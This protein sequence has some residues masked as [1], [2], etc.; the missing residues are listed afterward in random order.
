MPSK[1][2]RLKNDL[3]WAKA[4]SEWKEGYP[5]LDDSLICLET[6]FYVKFFPKDTFHDW[7]EEVKEEPTCSKDFAEA[8][9]IAARGNLHIGVVGY[10]V[11]EDWLT[12][13]TAKEE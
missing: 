12:A 9:K 1:R 11:S 5:P 8:I 13:H 10:L 2:Y 7:F 6:D 4:G 3:P